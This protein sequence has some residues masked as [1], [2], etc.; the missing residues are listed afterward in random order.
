MKWQL[1]WTCPTRPRFWEASS[2]KSNQKGA[3]DGAIIDPDIGIGP[4]DPSLRRRIHHQGAQNFQTRRS[5]SRVK[6]LLHRRPAMGAQ[7]HGLMKTSW[8]RCYSPRRPQRHSGLDL[9]PVLKRISP[10]MF[11]ARTVYR[12]HFR[13]IYRSVAQSGSALHWGC[14]GRRFKSYRPTIS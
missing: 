4:S 11:N 1:N 9:D 14:R 7:S 13:E 5:N 2:A 3:G 8:T 12:R 6:L 10:L